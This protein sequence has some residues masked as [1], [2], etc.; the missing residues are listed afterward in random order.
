MWL[1]THVLLNCLPWTCE[2]PGSLLYHRSYYQWF[3]WLVP[4][5]VNTYRFEKTM[6]VSNQ[7]RDTEA[8][9]IWVIIQVNIEKVR[10]SILKKG[11]N[12]MTLCW[13][14]QGLR[15]N[16]GCSGH[17]AVEMRWEEHRWVN[18]AMDS[19]CIVPQ[20]VQYPAQEGA[21]SIDEQWLVPAWAE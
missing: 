3:P 16:H 6:V 7:R 13:H 14:F 11:T 5:T 12:E 10:D 15:K 9:L 20:C 8:G 4:K 19:V 17:H 2:G 1:Q 18:G 21:N